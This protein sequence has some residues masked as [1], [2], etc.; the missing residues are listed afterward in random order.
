MTANALFTLTVR[1][2]E[3][4]RRAEIHWRQLERKAKAAQARRR[5]ARL[6]ARRV[7][8]SAKAARKSA[9]LAVRE[10]ERAA[11]QLG[12]RREKLAKLEKKWAKIAASTSSKARAN[13]AKLSAKKKV[14]M[15]AAPK[16]KSIQTSKPKRTRPVLAPVTTAAKSAAAKPAAA[17]ST[18][19]LFVRTAPAVSKPPSVANTIAETDCRKGRSPAC[20]E[21][22]AVRDSDDTATSRVYGLDFVAPGGTAVSP[23]PFRTPGTILRRFSEGRLGVDF[24][25]DRT[26]T[27]SSAERNRKRHRRSMPSNSLHAAQG[28][29]ALHT[30]R[31][32]LSGTDSS[33]NSGDCQTFPDSRTPQKL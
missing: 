22:S 16:A 1:A 9:K 14:G 21:S 31:F 28:P 5:Q 11:C 27:D 29:D 19:K 3:D 12:E 2:K 26:A 7:R 33:M 32:S 6:L 30:G 15:A 20:G 25:A 4:L 18:P 8:K 24:V 17:R 13:R 23:P 10:M